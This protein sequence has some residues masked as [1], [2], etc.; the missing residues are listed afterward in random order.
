[1][2]KRV[3]NKKLESDQPILLCNSF[4][5]KFVAILLNAALI[6]LTTST[7]NRAI[8]LPVSLTLSTF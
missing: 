5:E 3:G 2:E 6:R 7:S 4:A 8:G 1:M